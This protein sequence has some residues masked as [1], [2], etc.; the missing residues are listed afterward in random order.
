[1]KR[2]L[3]VQNLKIAE[4]SIF[5]FSKLSVWHSFG[6]NHQNE[7][8]RKLLKVAYSLFRSFSSDTYREKSSEWRKA[9]SDDFSQ[10]LSDENLQENEYATL[11]NFL[12]KFS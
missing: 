9:Q 1:M 10:W 4:S 11:S 2:F 3:V 5:I 8:N 7:E 6:E 12:N